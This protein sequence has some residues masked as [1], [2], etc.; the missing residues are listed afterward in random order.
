MTTPREKLAEQR[1]KAVFRVFDA[2]FKA[3][4]RIT[5]GSATCENAAGADA[6]YARL[7]ERLEQSGRRDIVLGRVGCAGKCDMEP[8]VTVVDRAGIPT[9]YILMN[10]ARADR[11]SWW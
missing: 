3:P 11:V 6:V 9:K 10:P 5:V 4:V 2:K 1:R 7:R 8:L